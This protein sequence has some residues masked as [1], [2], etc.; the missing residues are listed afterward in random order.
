M[1]GFTK[2]GQIGDVHELRIVAAVGLNVVN[3]A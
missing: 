2:R 1:T 3:F